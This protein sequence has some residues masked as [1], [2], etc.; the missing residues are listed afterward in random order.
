MD[1]RHTPVV[2]YGINN[3]YI[4]NVGVFVLLGAGVG[5]RNGI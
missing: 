2:V 1:Y 3:A 4:N 5:R